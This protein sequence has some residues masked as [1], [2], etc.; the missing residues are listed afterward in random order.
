MRKNLWLVLLLFLC[1]TM[2]LH[3]TVRGTHL[4]CNLRKQNIPVEQTTQMIGTWMKTNA[5]MSFVLV[6]D[7][8]DDLGF[9]HM[10][11]EQLLNGI[12]V[13]AARLIVHSKTKRT[14]LRQRHN[15]RHRPLWRFPQNLSQEMHK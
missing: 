3:A 1:S 7:E 11:Y 2:M 13:D 9:R 15:E 12:P 10:T 4:N 5:H 6:K 8:T 14:S